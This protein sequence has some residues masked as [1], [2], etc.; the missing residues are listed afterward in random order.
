MPKRVLIWSSFELKTIARMTSL[1]KVEKLN[2]SSILALSL[3]SY[4]QSHNYMQIISITVVL[5]SNRPTY[6]ICEYMK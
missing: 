2:L 3:P 6:N 1:K 5:L 4:S